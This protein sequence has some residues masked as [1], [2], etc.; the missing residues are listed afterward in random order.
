MSFHQ[1]PFK[2]N[3]LHNCLRAAGRKPIC[4][5]RIHRIIVNKKCYQNNAQKIYNYIMNLQDCSFYHKNYGN[6]LKKNMIHINHN[7][8]RYTFVSKRGLV[9]GIDTS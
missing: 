2:C 4:W 5:S 9:S 8:A 1:T 7:G 6:K 3:G